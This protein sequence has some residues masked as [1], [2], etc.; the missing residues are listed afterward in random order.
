MADYEEKDQSDPLEPSITTWTD[1]GGHLHIDYSLGPIGLRQ[2]VSREMLESAPSCMK[3]VHEVM[4]K[5]YECALHALAAQ[6]INKRFKKMLNDEDC[7]VP[8][9]NEVQLLPILSMNPNIAL[10]SY[11]TYSHLMKC[12]TPETHTESPL[13]KLPFR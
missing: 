13:M 6:I 12:A 7:F 4:R 9:I 3:A 1:E 11:D 2:L 10:V 8:A 5:N